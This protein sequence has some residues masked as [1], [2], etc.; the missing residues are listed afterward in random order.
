MIISFALRETALRAPSTST[1]LAV[2]ALPTGNDIVSALVTTWKTAGPQTIHQAQE[3]GETAFAA[4]FVVAFLQAMLALIQFRTNPKGLLV[5][6]PGTTEGTVA[7]RVECE[8]SQVDPES[9]F[10]A[11]RDLE[12]SFT[13]I[14]ETGM[15][16]VMP[17]DK[18]ESSS[19]VKRIN[20]ALFLL[21]PLA[22]NVLSFLIQRNIHLWHLAF[23]LSLSQILDLP[24]RLFSKQSEYTS[25]V[26]VENTLAMDK[27]ITRV[28]VL[29]DSLAAGI[30]AFDVFEEEIVGK[31]PE[32]GPGPVLP[33]ALAQR[34][35]EHNGQPVHWRSTGI[36]GGDVQDIYDNCLHI[37]R[38][39]VD[40][41][42]PPDLVMVICGINDLKLF[43]TNPV[44]NAGPKEFRDRMT[45]LVSKIREMSPGTKVVLPS[46]PTQM[47]RKD[48]PLN[49]FPLIFLLNTVVG[50]WDS[51]KKIVAKKFPSGEVLYVGLDPDEVYNWY[52][53]DPSKYGVPKDLD[54]D[55]VEDK[56]LIAR[57]G[58]HPNARC[59][60]FWGA[61]LGDKLSMKKDNKNMTSNQTTKDRVAIPTYLQNTDITIV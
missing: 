36:V 14:R 51:Q 26:G 24:D 52:M 23:F 35:S 44:K 16:S 27:P 6:P 25:D 49:I 39:E 10:N 5:V 33:R 45:K 21:I 31:P 17:N 54:G 1:V 7:P 9:W 38:E 32:R 3:W 41:G 13:E 37:V 48:H 55:G 11:L 4:M 29:G 43:A 50:F 34:I 8:E 2:D 60:A 42:R 20:K 47:L 22:S 12:S 57:D 28:I 58:V 30:G 61:S 40:K 59:Y 53:S 56:T 46:L 15:E 19:L 18:G